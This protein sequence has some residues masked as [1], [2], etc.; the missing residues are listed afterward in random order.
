MVDKSEKFSWL[1]RVGYFSRAILYIM[2]GFIAL[3]AASK[4]SEGSDGIFRAIEE[5]PGG[6]VLLG[7]MAAG[8]VGYALFRLCSPLFDIENEGSDASGWAKRIGHAGSAVGHLLLAWSAYKFATA[9]A[10]QSGAQSGDGAQQAAAG[11]L[12]FPFGGTA[13]ALLGVAF[14]FAAV[15]QARKGI[16]G[17]FMRRISAGAPAVTKTLGSV[18]YCARAAVYAVIGWSLI[19]AG[20]FSEGA[21]EVRTLGDALADLAGNTVVFQLVAAGL[22]VFGVFSLILA[23]YRIIPDLQKEDCLPAALA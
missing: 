16:S 3:T 7:V 15:S 5:F 12:S 6:P 11:V 21:D 10:A 19:K 13:L 8:L 18:G 9:D 17:S 4:V 23:R 14:F 22:L 2:I 20:W 1:V